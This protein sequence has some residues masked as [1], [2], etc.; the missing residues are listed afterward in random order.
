[1]SPEIFGQNR[2][3]GVCSAII[4]HVDIIPHSR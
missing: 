1:L 2:D 3:S 4:V